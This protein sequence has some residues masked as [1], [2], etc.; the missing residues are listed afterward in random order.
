MARSY[1]ESI[2]SGSGPP[3]AATLWMNATAS[4]RPAP[5]LALGQSTIAILPS[6]RNRRLSERTSPCRSVFGLPAL[7]DCAS[8]SAS[9]GRNLSSHSETSL[10]APPAT[11]VS[12]SSASASSVKLRHPVQSLGRGTHCGSSR[13]A[14][15]LWSCA[16]P[17]TPWRAYQS[18]QGPTPRLSRTNSRSKICQ[19]ATSTVPSSLG[20]H[21]RR[22]GKSRYSRISFRKSR[23]ITR[24][25]AL[26]TPFK[27]AMP[28]CRSVSLNVALGVYPPQ[29]RRPSITVLPNASSTSR[30][31]SAGTEAHVGLSSAP[32][33]YRFIISRT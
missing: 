2:C 26:L 20:A 29:I 28:P 18:V 19:S 15:A 25:P 10:P 23:R 3:S 21:G 33:R 7:V 32:L 5:R 12:P 1:H 16:S 27:N 30:F 4:N 24:F 14:N 31:T 13:F 6:G 17:S 8:N 22:A 11:V 9:S